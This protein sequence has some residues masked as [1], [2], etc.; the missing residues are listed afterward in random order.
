MA[1]LGHNATVNTAQNAIHCLGSIVV[2]EA[3]LFYV[4]NCEMGINLACHSDLSP[5]MSRFAS[6]ALLGGGVRVWIREQRKIERKI[7][8]TTN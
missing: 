1:S 5:Y 8:N 3:E 2:H 7:K 6:N 4:M